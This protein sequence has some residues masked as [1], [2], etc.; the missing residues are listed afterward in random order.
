M[1]TRLRGAELT[2]RKLL[3]GMLAEVQ[4][5]ILRYLEPKLARLDAVPQRFTFAIKPEQLDTVFGRVEKENGRETLKLIGIKPPVPKKLRDAFRKTNVNLVKSIAE[6]QL[7][8]LTKVLDEGFKKGSDQHTM[9]AAIKERFD[10]SRS[11]ADLIARD[12]ILKLNADMTEARQTAAGITEYT[13]SSSSDERVRPM[14]AE[15]DGTRQSWDDPPV[16]NDDG[17][18]NHPGQDYQCRCVAIPILPW[19]ANP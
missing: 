18:A 13:W 2:Y 12:Q 3:R 7:D 16:T 15:L 9:R 6:D 5:E 4:A 11:R 1:S 10:V 17:E 8:E 14:H 19:E